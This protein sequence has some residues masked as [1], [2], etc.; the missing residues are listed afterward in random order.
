MVLSPP[1][2]P[3]F[4]MRRVL[5]MDMSIINLFD[6]NN[7]LCSFLKYGTP[8]SLIYNEL[9]LLLKQ[10]ARFILIIRRLISNEFNIRYMK[11][12]F[13]ISHFKICYTTKYTIDLEYLIQK[14]LF[15]SSFQFIMWYDFNL[16]TWPYWVSVTIFIWRFTWSQYSVIR[17]VICFYDLAFVDKIKAVR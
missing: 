2:C 7:L 6:S 4:I 8:N 15:V 12:H 1:S 13:T 3:N 9:H 17:I 14:L 11:A 16:W 10:I 5:T